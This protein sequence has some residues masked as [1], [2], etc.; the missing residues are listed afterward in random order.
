MDGLWFEGVVNHV[1]YPRRI[2]RL[3]DRLGEILQNHFARKVRIFSLEIG[4]L[5]AKVAANVDEDRSIWVPFFGLLLNWVY[6]EPSGLSFT[7]M[8]HVLVEMISV[9]RVL[10][11]PNKDWHRW[12]L[13]S[14][15]GHCV[16]VVGDVLIILLGQK[17]RKR[18]VQW[19]TAVKPVRP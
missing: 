5:V 8:H 3:A 16:Y 11:K 9:L 12:N 10:G 15:L 18:L 13:V 2:Q 1:L 4:T 14:Y 7:A 19:P 6:L 17:F